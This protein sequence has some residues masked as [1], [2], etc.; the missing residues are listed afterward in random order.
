MGKS[1]FVRVPPV[2]RLF[3][4][5]NQCFLKI[6]HRPNAKVGGGGSLTLSQWE[7]TFTIGS[8]GGPLTAML[9]GVGGGEVI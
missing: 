5:W 3:S 7:L 1:S 4:Y 9:S 8:Y 6:V 2:E